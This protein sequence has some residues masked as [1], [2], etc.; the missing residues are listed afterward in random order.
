MSGA[1]LPIA[2]R[3]WWLTIN[4]RPFDEKF[5]PEPQHKDFPTR[6]TAETEKRLL[7]ACFGAAAAVHVAPV[8]ISR[9]KRER[10]LATA[11]GCLAVTGWPVQARPPRPG[12]LPK[13]RGR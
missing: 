1:E 2:W 13:K 8:Y 11:Q 7:A 6:E 5:R 4:G 3:V 12:A 10:K 9:P